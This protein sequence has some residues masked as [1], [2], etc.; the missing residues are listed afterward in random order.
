M[1]P[2]PHLDALGII[3]GNGRYPILLAEGFYLL[4]TYAD[5]LVLQQFRPPDE[6]AVYYAAAKT[7]ALVSF[8]YYAISATTAHRFSVY[9][10]AGDRERDPPLRSDA[11][12]CRRPRERPEHRSRSRP[13]AR[14]AADKGDHAGRSVWPAGRSRPAARGE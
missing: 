4:L 7:L 14:D 10:V 5:I 11:G 3:A 6:V 9:H 2:A 13:R 8:I 12:L 1:N